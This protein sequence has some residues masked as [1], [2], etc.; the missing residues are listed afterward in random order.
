MT[1]GRRDVSSGQ[2]QAFSLFGLFNFEGG[3]PRENISHKAAMSWIEMLNHHDDGWETFREVTQH[4]TQRS[5]AARG[6]GKCDNVK[7]IPDTG[8]ILCVIVRDRGSANEDRPAKDPLPKQVIRDRF[9]DQ[10]VWSVTFVSGHNSHQLVEIEITQ[11]GDARSTA[12]VQQFAD[13]RAKRRI[14]EEQAAHIFFIFV[15]DDQIN[16]RAGLDLRQKNIAQNSDLAARL[17][18]Y[19]FATAPG[20]DRRP[21]SDAAIAH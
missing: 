14:G 18:V 1:V 8:S 13:L 21:I 19:S 7:A 9:A 4:M 16:S 11:L 20:P 5:E 17:P 10:E 2:I 12:F 3:A 6:S 15:F